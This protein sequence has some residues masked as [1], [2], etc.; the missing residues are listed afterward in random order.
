M[1][2]ARYLILCIAVICFSTTSSAITVRPGATS[3]LAKSHRKVKVHRKPVKFI[4]WE[5]N[6]LSTT[7][8]TFIIY[9]FVQVIDRAQSKKMKRDFKE[10]APTVELFFKD[11]T[12]VK[13]IIR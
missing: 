13:V 11:R 7:A 3:T 4:G 5:G 6:R 10:A 8:G 9:P 12:L 2:Y 1:K